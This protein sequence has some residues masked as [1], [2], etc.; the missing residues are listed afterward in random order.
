MD[1]LT[2]SLVGLTAAKA[3][4]DKLSPGATTLCVLA[5]N[6]PDVDIVVL[7][8][9]GRWPFL[10]HHRGITHSIVGCLVLSVLLPLSFY[11][12]D[13]IISR[14]KK[15]KPQVRLGGLMLASVLVTATH[16]LLDWTNNY[17]MRF[18]LPWNPRWWYGDFAFVID[19][20]IW[21]CLGSAAFLLTTK[22]TIKKTLW[23]L[24]GVIASYLVLI[25]SSTQARE[26]NLIPLRVMWVVV[27]VALVVAYRREVRIRVPQRIALLALTIVLIYL[28]TLA[29]LHVLALRQARVRAD[30]IARSYSEQLKQVAAMPVLATP[31][32]WSCVMETE[33]ATY[34]FS[35]SLLDRDRHSNVSRFEK[36]TGLAA[37]AIAE[38]DRDPRAQ[39]LNEF[40]RFPGYNVVGLDCATQTL[41]QFAD[42][43]YTEP[44]K[45]NGSFSLEV[46]IECPDILK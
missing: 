19:P 42:L 41:V 15:R 9:S 25:A 35:V 10:H 33:K 17:G 12:G 22:T 23:I 24:L 46:P 2:H 1:N 31:A 45:R 11:A 44:G 40:M 34:K 26:G 3:G 37:Y 14:L 20:F 27:I 4:L 30:E 28:T 18:L 38:A 16:P 39:V 29:G 13:Q 8:T 6:A 32:N 36:P 7:L 43:R 21:L 5:A